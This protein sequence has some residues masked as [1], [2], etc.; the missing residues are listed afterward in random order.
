MASLLLK[1]K[2]ADIRDSL[3]KR[4]SNY[5][6]DKKQRVVIPGASSDWS[7]VLAGVPQGRF[8]YYL[9]FWT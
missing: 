7:S 8:S 3:L 1:L 2:C 6:L 4:F 5:V 9:G